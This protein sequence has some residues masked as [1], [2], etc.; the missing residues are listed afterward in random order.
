MISLEIE[1]MDIHSRTLK[2]KYL[3]NSNR[4]INETIDLANLPWDHIYY[5]LYLT[6]V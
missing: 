2:Q 3:S 6:M 4:I 5:G 1:V